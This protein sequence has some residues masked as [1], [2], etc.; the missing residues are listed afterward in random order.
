MKK[1]VLM[2]GVACLL[3]GVSSVEALEYKPYVSGK[4]IFSRSHNEFKAFNG[5]HETKTH[6]SKNIWGLSVA[7]GVEAF[8]TETGTVRTELEFN[9]REEAVRHENSK[10]TTL[11]NDSIMVNAYYDFNTNTPITPYVGAGIGYARVDVKLEEAGFKHTKKS[12]NF[13]WQLGAGVAYEIDEHV[14]VDLGYR[15]ADAGEVKDHTLPGEKYKMKA[16][17]H[18]IL[19]GARYSF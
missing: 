10:K 9:G 5:G 2:A 14:A 12:N 13:A 11:S 1:T 6:R 8:Q 17:N 19:L 7:G 3:L 4:A 16:M 18:E 15:F